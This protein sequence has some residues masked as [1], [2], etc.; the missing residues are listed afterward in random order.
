MSSGLSLFGIVRKR[1]SELYSDFAE[2]IKAGGAFGPQTVLDQPDIYKGDPLVQLASAASASDSELWEA[3][4]FYYAQ[5]NLETASGVF[6]DR[7]HG[8]RAGVTRALDQSDTDFRAAIRTVLQVLPSRFD[9][10]AIALNQ[11]EVECAA[12]VVVTGDD[13]C[14]AYELVIRGCKPDYQ[15][16]AQALFDS[17]DLGVYSMQGDIPVSVSTPNGGC[18]TY[19][20]TEAQPIVIGVRVYGTATDGCSSID[21]VS[22]LVSAALAAFQAGCSFGGQFDAAVL[23]PILTAI[24]GFQ[25]TRVEVARRARQLVGINCDLSGLPQ[26]EVC[27]ETAAWATSITCGN[28]AGEIWC[29]T[30][31]GGCADLQSF[32]YPIFDSQFIEVI[33]GTSC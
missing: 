5:F 3:V 18:V 23:L 9:P 7:L 4:E 11:P 29:D 17:A 27:G 10:T 16:L 1:M 19:R 21:D 25:V 24:D 30:D 31:F 14:P 22:A 12:G 26:I 6:L 8:D 13:G 2:R 15:A 33:E 32:E 20:F 28:A